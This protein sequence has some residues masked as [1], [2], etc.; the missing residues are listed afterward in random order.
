MTD[1]KENNTALHGRADLGVTQ[2]E[3]NESTLI[4]VN[5]LC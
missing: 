3:V 4:N 2:V 1:S 5:L